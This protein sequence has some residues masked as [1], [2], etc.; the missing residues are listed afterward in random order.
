MLSQVLGGVLGRGGYAP[1]LMVFRGRWGARR[2]EVCVHAQMT[3]WQAE[4]SDFGKWKTELFP[5]VNGRVRSLV[6]CCRAHQDR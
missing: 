3:W 6:L 4:E 1:S 5:A 2:S